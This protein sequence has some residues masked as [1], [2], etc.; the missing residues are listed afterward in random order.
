MNQQSGFWLSDAVMK[1][2]LM[3]FMVVLIAIPN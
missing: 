1:H 3:I 2:G